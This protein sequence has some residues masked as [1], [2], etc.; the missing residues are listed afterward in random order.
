MFAKVEKDFR[1]RAREVTRLEG[2]SDAVFAFALTLL[3]VSLEV[4][5]SYDELI[6]AMKGFAAFGVCFALLAQ[7]WVNHHRYFR[8][9][10][11]QDAWVVFLNFVLLFVVLLYVY[12]LKFLWFSAWNGGEP[13]TV[14]H[15]RVLLVIYGAGYAAVFLTFALLYQYAWQKRDELELTA[16]ER[17]KTQQSLA[18]HLAMAL[19]GLVSLLLALL[20]PPEWVGL[21]GYFY[22]SVGVYFTISGTFFGRKARAL[23]RG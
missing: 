17:L 15:V 1:W 5:K 14:P 3:V 6:N 23:A 10:G 22:F 7:L 19:V 21:A 18:D 8:R 16:M 20:L 2:F 11:L 12:P 9:Y 13:Q 4:P